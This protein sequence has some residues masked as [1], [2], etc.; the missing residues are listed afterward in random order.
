M[1]GLIADHPDFTDYDEENFALYLTVLQAR[2]D[3]VP[4]KDIAREVFGLDAEM[5]P[6]AAAATVENHY[7]RALWLAEN[8]A[9]LLAS[10][11][12]RQDR[13]RG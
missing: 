2:A 4:D 10:P 13:R 6:G 5:D 8:G 7:R 9:T 11:I 3:G 12:E 1:A